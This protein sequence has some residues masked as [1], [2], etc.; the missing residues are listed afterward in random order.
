MKWSPMSYHFDEPSDILFE[1]VNDQFENAKINNQNDS[2]SKISIFPSTISSLRS[3]MLRSQWVIRYLFRIDQ[4]WVW[5][6]QKSATIESNISRTSSYYSIP[7]LFT[8]E[9]PMSWDVQRDQMSQIEFE[10]ILHI[11]DSFSH[12]IRSPTKDEFEKQNQ[13][14][15]R[16]NTLRSISICRISRNSILTSSDLVDDRMIEKVFRQISEGS[17]LSISKIIESWR[18][19]LDRYRYDEPE[20]VNLKENWNI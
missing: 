13:P 16:S 10:T 12:T 1:S 11:D 19:N 2:D 15:K 18:V 6:S 3:D 17:K 4:R 7:Q 8:Y 9:S 5:K 20:E 14:G